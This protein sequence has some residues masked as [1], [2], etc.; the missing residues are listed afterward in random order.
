V[1][2]GTI[3]NIEPSRYDLATAYLT[4]DG[5]QVNNRDPWVYKTT[6]FG[7][8]WK[9][10]T[11][12]LAKTPLSYAH[13][14]REDPVRRGL[15]Y[16]GTEGGL[17]VSFNDGGSWQP[18]QSNLPHAPVY[19]IVVQPHYSDLVVAT[20]GRGFWIMDD[21][22]PLRTLGSAVTT[23]A[24]HLFPPRVAYRL[25]TTEQPFAV[26]YDPS[27]GF[28]PPDGAP[29]NFYLKTG[30]DSTVKDSAGKTI[31]SKD[32]VSITISDAS[33][34]LVRTLKAPRNAGINRV[35][36][37][38]RGDL[39]KQA[40]IRTSPEYAPWFAVSLDGRDAPTVGRLGVAQPPGTYTVKI[41]GTSE[42]QPLVV[43]KDPNTGG[44][45]ATLMENVAVGRNIVADLD[46]TV[47]MINALENVR[48]QLAALKAS[49][50]SDSTR[51]DV[52]TAADSLDVKL[53]VV[54]RKLFQTRAT[55]R[56]QDALRWPSRI[57][58]QLQY[59][60]G[61][62]ESSDFAPTESQKQVA[63]LLRS[64][65]RAVKTEFDRVMSGD[66]AAFNAML[67]QRKV[68]NVISN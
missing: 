33:G 15:L 49:I 28:N 22:T 10:I 19:W 41:V 42:S 13:V 53:R 48:G 36:W 62:I 57:S 64:Q 39:T 6:D 24:A 5:H 30:S 51:K 55:G 40:K 26:N 14:V 31:V 12:G 1:P 20:Y 4:V 63:D 32:S 35:W 65:V 17:Y 7:K 38:L 58:E 59:L 34:A 44:T 68:P 27:S 50:S 3:S 67:Q 37:N 2:W 8:T 25:H 43:K 46:S 47:T 56:G 29:I 66:V 60:A 9:L 23:K 16:L 18:L 45:D 54:E 11:T 21:I 52:V 61:E